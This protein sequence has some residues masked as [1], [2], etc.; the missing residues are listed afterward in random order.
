MPF[1]KK[2]FAATTRLVIRIPLQR[3]QKPPARLSNLFGLIDTEKLEVI[4]GGGGGVRGG[5]AYEV[6]AAAAAAGLEMPMQERTSD[7]MD[8]SQLGGGSDQDS[9]SQLTPK[10]AYDEAIRRQEATRGRN[11]KVNDNK[12]MNVIAPIRYEIS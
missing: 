1:M 4:F 11:G 7:L 8:S 5:R 3:P 6:D 10:E 2:N 12:S 9:T